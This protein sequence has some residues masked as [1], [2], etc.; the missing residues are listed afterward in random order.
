[1]ASRT[2]TRFGLILCAV[3]IFLPARAFAQQTDTTHALP[4]DTLDVTVT[5]TLTPLARVPAALSVVTREQIQAAR[6]GIGLD[7]ALAQVP[8]VVVSNRYNFAQGTRISIR[9]F[10][11]RAAF[12]V[13]G[14]KVI[15]DGIPLTMPDGQSTL[16]NIDLSS[17]GHI[18]VLRGAASMLYGNAA[19]GVIEIHSEDPQPG[20]SAQAR[21]LAGDFGR[22]SVDNL[23]K[24]ALKAGGGSE[25]TR[26]LI[27]ADRLQTDGFR[28]HSRF[29]QTNVNARVQHA[30]NS[31]S[32][33]AL[34]LN[35]YDSPYAE[36]PGALPRDSM[37]RDP[38]MAWPRNIT[39]G[40]GKT[41]KQMQLGVQHH[42][43]FGAATFDATAYGVTRTL[44]NPQS[45]AYIM[46]DRRA[47][48]VRSTLSWPH[49]TLGV[50]A[51]RMADKR[52]EYDNPNGSPGPN[53]RRDQTDRIESVG[54]FIRAEFSPV[55]RA[56]ITAG[57][58]Y[59]VSRF[60]IADR[61]LADSRDDSGS[62][63][64]S[65]LSP[66]IGAAFEM[67]HT[68][69]F[70]NLSTSFQT[71]TTTEMNN[72][73]PAP[74]QPCCAAGFNPLD[75][76]RALSLEAGVRTRIH[77][78]SADAAVFSV[79]TRDK[80]VPFQVANA[81]DRDFYRN[82]GV[83]SQRGVELA[84]TA[85]ISRQLQLTTSYTYNHFIFIDD[86][87][88][89]AHDEGNQ[90]P[91]VPPHHLLVRATA[92]ADA[93]VIEPEVEWTSSFFA[94]DTNSA[95]SRNDAFSVFNVR[96]H[97]AHDLPGGLSPFVAVNNIL[98]AH[99]SGSVVIN[100]TGG[101]YFEPAPGRNFYIG[102]AIRAGH[103]GLR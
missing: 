89:S 64:M 67:A 56:N 87:I 79:R 7:E 12:G 49:I 24:F 47:G 48:G 88:D 75:P 16:N 29:L 40:A 103:G 68:T 54:P 66:S 22:S 3:T 17:A 28:E 60:S 14:I 74:G 61:F 93:I 52:R 97:P 63:T 69:L 6:P 80:I 91:G 10:G 86:G 71:P 38:Q 43:R 37:L 95:A 13:R 90:L 42:Q 73:P 94:D 18:E 98:D 39:V 81:E 32:R 8:G 62:R 15:E 33:T 55:Q 92:T 19:G 1:M 35:L 53:Q 4:V 57:L 70:A 99:Y 77:G 82:A 84:L 21:A 20:F 26:Y 96:I 25:S 2:T 78:V 65:A 11:S 58:R 46:L 41:S 85:D 9:G 50:D 23:G 51:D 83:T 30:F 72:T 45:F 31:A 27:S 100:A 76:E 44:D 5:R 102:V 36:D 59:D 34:T 101:R